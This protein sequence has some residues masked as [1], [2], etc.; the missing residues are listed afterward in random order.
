MQGYRARMT[1]NAVVAQQS[2]D[3]RVGAGSLGEVLTQIG[4]LGTN[5]AKQES[6]LQEQQLSAAHQAEIAVLQQKRSAAIAQNMGAMAELEG[7]IDQEL[8][9]QRNFVNPTEWDAKATQ[10]I[11]KKWTKFSDSLGDDPEVRDRFLPAIAR[12][13]ASTISREEDFSR[14]QRAKANAKGFETWATVSKGK[15]S[16]ADKP[17]EVFQNF[18]TDLTTYA[19]GLDLPRAA[20]AE[21]IQ[22]EARDGAMQMFDRLIAQQRFDEA[23]KLVNAP[24]FDALLGGD[25]RER[26]I[27]NVGL[28]RRSVKAAELAV[29]VAARDKWQE[30]ARLVEEMRRRGAVPPASM[31]AELQKQGKAL[32][33]GADDLYALTADSY[34]DAINRQ[35][36]PEND[37]TGE[38]ARAMEKIL[39]PKIASGKASA[40]E[41]MM[42]KQLQGVGEARSKAAGEALR[43]LAGQGPQGQMQVLGQISGMDIDQRFNAG[44]AAGQNLGYVALMPKQAQ[45]AVLK[46]MEDMATPGQKILDV[47]KAA[48]AFSGRMKTASLGFSEDALRSYLEIANGYYAYYAKQQGIGVDQFN[49]EIYDAA[50]RVAFGGERRVGPDGKKRWFGGAGMFGKTP[51]LLP[52]HMSDQMFETTVY[53]QPYNDAYVANGVK[54]TKA[55]VL[56]NFEPVWV[57]NDN[58]ADLYYYRQKATGKWLK[59]KDGVSNYPLRIPAG[60]K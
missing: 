16:R 5:L 52:D 9:A 29:Q 45:E 13:R 12:Q 40:E 37:P 39:A 3:T 28:E 38:R 46:G 60:A 30:Q 20:V 1:G 42:Y 31:I 4:A 15:L 55:D 58:G 44:E 47:K 11:K 51:V 17:D 27:K 19:S 59:L 24:E 35:F 18:I 33:V 7:S 21:L 49:P 54:T 8:D 26:I 2:P 56:A 32:G 6:Q 14:V 25:P 43:D 53:R 48:G 41:Q 50:V 22:S 36:G 23:E 34:I 10:I 57:G